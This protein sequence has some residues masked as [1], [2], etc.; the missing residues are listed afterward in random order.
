MPASAARDRCD[1]ILI[2]LYEYTRTYI[3]ANMTIEDSLVCTKKWISGS[4]DMD[5]PRRILITSSHL[6][7]EVYDQNE[8]MILRG[9]QLRGKSPRLLKFRKNNRKVPG[10]ASAPS[11]KNT[12]SQVRT[13][14]TRASTNLGTIREGNFLWE[15]SR[16]KSAPAVRLGKFTAVVK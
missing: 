4:A 9:S 12:C 10:V 2:I 13:R 11:A 7:R 14:G 8:S 15:N 3:G 16:C 5:N 6:L 1:R